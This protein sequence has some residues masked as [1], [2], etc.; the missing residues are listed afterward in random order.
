MLPALEPTRTMML[1]ASPSCRPDDAVRICWSPQS[2]SRVTGLA[3]CGVG[4]GLNPPYEGSGGGSVYPCARSPRRKSANTESDVLG[5]LMTPMTVVPRNADPS[6]R[7]P[8]G[9]GTR[10]A[11]HSGIAPGRICGSPPNELLTR[12]P[13]RSIDTESGRMRRRGSCARAALTGAPTI[14]RIGMHKEGRRL[15]AASL[16][17]IPWW[18]NAQFCTGPIGCARGGRS[19]ARRACGERPLASIRS[20]E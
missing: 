8:G 17:S 19:S 14:S 18:R 12:A 11:I 2:V 4:A 16:M 15:N 7:A 13:T 1:V 3:N 9:R 5:T 20:Q 10:V 6:T